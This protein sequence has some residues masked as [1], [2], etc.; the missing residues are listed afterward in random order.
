MTGRRSHLPPVGI[1]TIESGLERSS[2]DLQELRM[3]NALALERT[4]C[5]IVDGVQGGT[6]IPITECGDRGLIEVVLPCPATPVAT[7][8]PIV[9]VLGVERLPVAGEMPPRP[10][11]D[12]VGIAAANRRG[13][14]LRS[15]YRE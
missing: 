3:G 8:M 12:D 15:R 5:A 9:E 10:H 1:G 7:P 4:W 2:S 6:C 13:L 11:N 14:A